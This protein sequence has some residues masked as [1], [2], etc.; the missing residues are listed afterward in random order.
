MVLR[1]FAVILYS[2]PKSKIRVSLLLC[3]WC[4]DCR[5]IMLVL[6]NSYLIPALLL[7]QTQL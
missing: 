1:M 7:H 6:P 2:Q 3:S 4:Y 5:G